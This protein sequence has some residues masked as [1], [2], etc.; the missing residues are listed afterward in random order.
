[1]DAFIMQNIAYAFIYS[2][3]LLILAILIFDRREV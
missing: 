1:V 2:A 3:V